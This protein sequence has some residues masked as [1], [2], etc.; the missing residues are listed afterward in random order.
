MD[1]LIGFPVQYVGA[2]DADQVE[3]MHE[4]TECERL[5]FGDRKVEPIGNQRRIKTDT[6]SMIE[7]VT[8]LGFQEVGDKGNQRRCLIAMRGRARID[9]AVV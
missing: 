7:E 9:G 5:L 6:A 4:G 3:V 1:L 8:I 2:R